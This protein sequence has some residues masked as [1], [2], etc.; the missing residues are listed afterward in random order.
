MEPT[1][2]I[3]RQPQE[4]CDLLTALDERIRRAGPELA[5]SEAGGMLVYGPFRYRY[6]SG[7]EGTSALVS[8]AVRKGGVAVYVNSVR[9]DGTYVAEAHAAELGKVRVG[10]SCITVKRLKDL[11]LDGFERV[12]AEAVERG[13]AGAVAS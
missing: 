10:R 1:A 9:D 8:V 6:A 13:G 11:E 7:R 5:V 3:G 2:W 12:V 4:S